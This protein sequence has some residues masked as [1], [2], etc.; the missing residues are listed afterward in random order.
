MGA[1]FQMSESAV[2]GAALVYRPLLLRGWNDATG[3]HRA[4]EYLGF[5]FASLDRV[6][7][8]PRA[9][10]R[11]VALVDSLSRIVVKLLTHW[12]APSSPF[13]S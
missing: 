2:V 11:P 7:S 6:R 9:A 3:E 13:A 12:F 4:D 10:R 1:E 8:H 5:G